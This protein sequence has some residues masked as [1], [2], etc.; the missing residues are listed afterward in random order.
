[1]RGTSS[2]FGY[3][4]L[5]RLHSITG[6][7][8]AF[9]FVFCFLL[10]YSSV[11]DGA[12]AFNRLMADRMLIPML[13]WAQVFFIL[14]PLLYHGAF[15]LAV[16]HG[17]QINAFRYNYY[18]NWMYALQRFAGLL[19]IPFIVYHLYRTVLAQAV[20]SSPLSFDTMH[21]ILAPSW[22]KA[23]YIAG[24]VCLAFY[25]GNGLAMQSTAWGVAA[26]RRARGVAII[27]GWI[28]T[29]ALSVW[30]IRIVLSF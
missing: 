6:V 3:L 17:C 9:A 5:C 23:V 29:I 10:P 21:A 26:A 18:R 28:I 4:W 20:G 15:G 12:G 30:G 22:T 14:I 1:M 19:L 16:V 27:F 11:F 25:I 2:G 13:G 8:L 24:I 7:I